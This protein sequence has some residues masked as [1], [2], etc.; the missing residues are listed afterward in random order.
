MNFKSTIFLAKTECCTFFTFLEN[1]KVSLLK[2]QNYRREFEMVKNAVMM[3]ESCGSQPCLPGC[4]PGGSGRT[5]S[6]GAASYLRSIWSWEPL[7]YRLG[8]WCNN[9][10]ALLNRPL[11]PFKLSAI[12]FQMPSK[13]WTEYNISLLNVIRIVWSGC[14]S[15]MM[16]DQGLLSSVD[17]KLL[18]RRLLG[19]EV[20][21]WCQHVITPQMTSHDQGKTTFPVERCVSVTG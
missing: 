17:V 10:T 6:G 11:M 15:S 1:C 5:G 8:S 20:F 19:T 2:H 14:M 13:Y 12:Q 21:I 16:A 18:G 7:N 3:T 4:R 9:I